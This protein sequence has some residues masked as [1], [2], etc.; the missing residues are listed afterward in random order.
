MGYKYLKNVTIN[1]SD[2]LYY[3]RINSMNSLTF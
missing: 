2:E 3:K 1:K